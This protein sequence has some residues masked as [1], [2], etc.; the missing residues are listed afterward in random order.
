MS[1][2]EKKIAVLSNVN[3]SPVFRTLQGEVTLC[4][5]EGYGNELGTMMNPTSGYNV[6]E[7]ELTFLVMDLMELI[8]HDL[9]ETAVKQYVEKWFADLAGTL[10]GNRIYYI[11]DAYLWGSELVVAER[12]IP[13]TQ[14]EQIWNENLQAFCKKYS[15]VRILPYHQMLTELGEENAFSLKMWYMGKILLSGEALKRLADLILKKVSLE[16][17]VPKKVLVLDLDNTLWGGLAGENDHTPITLSDDHAGLAYK[18]LQRVIL[19]MQRQGVIL[20]IASK[21]N[22]E[23]A[24]EILKNHP[25]MVLGPDCFA[26]KRINWNPKNQSLQELASEL[27]LGTDSFVFF[28]DNPEERFLITE[29]MPEVIVP[30]FPA[31]PEDLAPAMVGIFHT[32][33]EK[34][35]LTEE[36]LVKTEN[37]VANAKRVE[38]QQT[39]GNFY[40]YLKELKIMV[41]RVETKEHMQ[42]L[43]AM[44]NK[45]NQFNLTTKRHDM[46]ELAAMVE[47]PEKFVYVYRVADR[48]GDNGVVAAAVVDTSWEV[49]I[50]EEF[51]MSCRVM[52]KNIEQGILKDIELDMMDQGYRRLR[53]LYAPTTKN[54]PVENFYPSMGYKLIQQAPDGMCMYEVQLERTPVRE[55]VGSMSIENIKQKEV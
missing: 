12:L 8:Q 54:K 47:D 15:N 53:S 30:E 52:G 43:E 32:Y 18:N 19:Q 11:S 39:A 25:H 55:F 26:A 1:L 48:F 28:D 7:P 20:A 27:N 14:I 23:D 42:R 35:V 36:D 4:P 10:R 6:F 2:A 37:Y 21:N 16:I 44:V 24:E 13:R 3:M 40:E 46:G 50:L 49:P 5:A 51:L 17:E 29:T 38:L 9:A 22:L 45:T 41:T 33:F 34:C 31:K